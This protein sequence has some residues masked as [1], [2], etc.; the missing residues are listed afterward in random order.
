M[1][2]LKLAIE[3]LAVTAFE[4][5]EALPRRG[6]TVRGHVTQPAKTN[7]MFPC[8]PAFTEEPSCAYTGCGEVGCSNMHTWC[9]DC[10]GSV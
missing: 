8:G 3:D 6:G 5:A 7:Q 1:K 2:K 10:T 4:T 9:A